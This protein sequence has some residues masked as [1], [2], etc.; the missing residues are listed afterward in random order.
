MVNAIKYLF[1]DLKNGG[2][3]KEMVVKVC[4]NIEDNISNNI[5]PAIDGLLNVKNTNITNNKI[6]Q[7]FSKDAELKGN[8]AT[9]SLNSLKNFFNSILNEFKELSSCVTKY[10]SNV[11][12]EKSIT[13]RDGAILRIVSDI[14]SISLYTL[15][16]LYSATNVNNGMSKKHK[17]QVSSMYVDYCSLIRA[18][19]K[20]LAKNIKSL[21]DISTEVVNLDTEPGL[22]DTLFSN[23]GK[24]I[25]LPVTNG[26][27]GNPIYH[28]RMWMADRDYRKY[29]LN[30]EKKRLL[31][32]KIL[33]LKAE[34]ENEG[35]D[36]NKLNRQIEYYEDLVN[37]I[38]HDISKYEND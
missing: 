7:K 15:D 18:Y 25:N 33:A 26:F 38:E 6:L 22:L 19:N 8:S 27:V 36:L 29:E 9:D 1:S 4:D 3:K 14:N 35:V 12:Y 23:T 34:K 30:K 31:E 28:F 10:L 37:D 32:L 24:L 5:I 2:I 11:V 21:K 13:A 20:N 16:F 17:D